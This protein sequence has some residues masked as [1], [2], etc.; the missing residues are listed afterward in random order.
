[1]TENSHPDALAEHF[2]L[3]ADLTYDWEYWIGPAGEFRYVSPS[4]ERITGYPPEDFV[5]DPGLLARIVH[6]DDRQLAE[7]HERGDSE[8]APRTVEYRIVTRGGEE[9]WIGHV[10]RPVYAADGSWAGYRASN[11]DITEAKRIEEA[12]SQQEKRYRQLFD[13]MAEGFALHEI[14]IDDQGQPCDYRFLEVNPAFEQL[15]GLNKED[16]LGKRVMEVLPATEPFWIETYGRVALTG[17]PVHFEHY[18]AAFGRHYAVSAYRPAEN[19]FASVFVDITDRVRTEQVLREN[20]EKLLTL[21][22][23]LPVGVSILDSA[24]DIRYLN[25][26]L[27]RMLDLPAETGAEA[28]HVRRSYTRPDGSP[29][30]AD[31]F[32]SVRAVREQRMIRDVEIGVLKEDGTQVWTHVS[33]AP[34]PFDDWSVIIVTADITELHH[35]RHELEE[36]VQ[37]R[38]IELTERTDELERA[39][40]RLQSAEEVLRSQNEEL[41]AA[42][43]R[44][45]EERQR[46]QE[47]FDLAPDGYLVTTQNSIIVEANRAAGDLLCVPV[48]QLPGKRLDQYVVAAD[49]PILEDVLAQFR[50]LKGGAPLHSEVRLQPAEGEPIHTSVA[51]TAARS[52][53]GEIEGVRWLLRDVTHERQMHDALVHS[54]KLSIVGQLAASFAHEIKNPLAAAIGCVDMVHEALD[55]GEDPGELLA[56]IQSSLDRASRLVAQLQELHQ[57]SELEEKRLANLNELVEEVLL[58]GTKR[59]QSAGVE[60]SWE[61]AKGLPNLPVMVDGIQQVLLNLVLNAIEAMPDGGHLDVRIRRTRRPARI[62]IQFAD[63]GPGLAPEI[64]NRLFEPFKTTKAQG[65]GLGLFVSHNIVHQHGG[66]ID[67]QSAEGQG[68]ALTVWLPV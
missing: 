13:G 5:A 60:I 16:L 45:E 7:Q 47:L 50:A 62:G 11:R 49:G 54:E 40:E 43:H 55:E 20:E 27:S 42:Q 25:P 30:P 35:A 52:I 24:R 48:G 4:C 41:E 65:S 44:L 34:L 36:R 59:A 2:R 68:T 12:L 63:D 66:S 32:P 29:M 26:A 22:E 19:Q 18:S 31:E 64:R 67:V 28:R 9:R 58:L 39:N 15:T 61:R 57:H 33:A 10:C 8:G 17:E 14:L 23:I 1:M 56:I 21:L 51:A 53:S 37:E 6:P 3:V 38:T 46:Y